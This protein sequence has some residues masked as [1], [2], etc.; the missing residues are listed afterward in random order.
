VESKISKKLKKLLKK[1]YVKELRDDVLAVAD[2][3]LS[4]DITVNSAHYPYPVFPV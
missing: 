3:K 2:K 4:M 1:L